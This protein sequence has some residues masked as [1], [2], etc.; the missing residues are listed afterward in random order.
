VANGATLQSIG[1]RRTRPGRQLI[2]AYRAQLTEVEAVV[3]GHVQ[4]W[5]DR[6]ATPVGPELEAMGPGGGPSGPVRS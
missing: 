6:R 4:A 2:A 1:R 5:R 3:N